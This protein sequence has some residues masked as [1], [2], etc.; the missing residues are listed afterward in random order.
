MDL[1]DFYKR[2]EV[3]GIYIKLHYKIPSIEGYTW[4]QM[5]SEN[6]GPLKFDNWGVKNGKP[7]YSGSVDYYT[8]KEL[9]KSFHNGAT[10]FTD[11]PI[12]PDDFNY[13]VEF[14]LALFRN[15]KMIFAI[16]YGYSI[17]NGLTFPIFPFIIKK[18]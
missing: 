2:T 12:N 15:R 9:S 1:D 14:T 18:P 16:H 7:Y 3:N 5:Y 10:Y 11:S 6:G 8:N 4:D 13:R 17:I